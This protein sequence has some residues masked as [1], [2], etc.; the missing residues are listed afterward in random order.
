MTYTI[1]AA[2]GEDEVEH[3]YPLRRVPQAVSQ[4]VLWDHLNVLVRPLAKSVAVS[5]VSSLVVSRDP[6]VRSTLE[7]RARQSGD[8]VF[9][10]AAHLL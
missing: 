8:A 3:Y 6:L 9:P 10:H 1:G 5:A 2:D 7:E 4:R